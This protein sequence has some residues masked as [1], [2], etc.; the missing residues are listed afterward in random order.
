MK[1]DFTALDQ[2][3]MSVVSYDPMFHALSNYATQLVTTQEERMHL[4]IKRQNFELQILSIYMTSA[5]KN[6]NEV[7]NIVK[8]VEG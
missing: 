7:I 4:F 5:R 8:K 1:D 2:G 6:I 3:G